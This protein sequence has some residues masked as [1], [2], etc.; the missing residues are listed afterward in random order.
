LSKALA[1]IG[2]GPLAPVLTLVLPTFAAYARR[3]G[4]QLIVGDGDADGRPPPWGKVVLLRRLLDD[5]DEALWIDAD[6][7]ILDDTVDLTRDVAPDAYQALVRHVTHDGDMPN[8]GVWFLRGQRGRDLL[9]AV[10]RRE[11][12]SHHRWWENAAALDLLGYSLDPPVRALRETPWV[13][14][15]H[16]LSPTWNAIPPWIPLP[17]HIRHYAGW[18]WAGLTPDDL[19]ARMREDR[20]QVAS[21]Q[22]WEGELATLDLLN[23]SEARQRFAARMGTAVTVTRRQMLAV[24][25]LADKRLLPTALYWGERIIGYQES[26]GGDSRWHA[27]VALANGTRV[28]LDEPQK[29]E[30]AAKAL[31]EAGPVEGLVGGVEEWARSA[32][33]LAGSAGT[34][35]PGVAHRDA[36]PAADDTG[37]RFPPGAGSHAD[38]DAPHQTE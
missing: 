22:R 36:E 28:L 31:G 13:A 10:W 2:T 1:T 17:C 3:H 35:Q 16:W 38:D 5:V 18:N 26:L 24:R 30:R 9:D 32:T 37:R 15:T 23:L 6:A 25:E 21:F 33:S 20:A 11:E 29:D 19:M 12:Y 4:F 27:Q 8:T 14:G 7:V 34:A